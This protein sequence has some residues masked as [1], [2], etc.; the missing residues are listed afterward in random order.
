MEIFEMSKNSVKNTKSLKNKSTASIALFLM[1]T[2][3]VTLV[4]LPV[5]NAHTP[6]WTIVSYAYLQ[7]GPNPVGVGQTVLILMW[8]DG[9]MRNAALE[10]DIRRH[11]YTLTITAPDGTTE[12]RN[13]PIILDPTST[14]FIR[15]TPTQ[16]GTYTLDFNYPGQTYTW[17]ATSSERTWTNDT[18]TAASATFLLTV[19]DEPLPAPTVS[20]PLPTEYW[21]R[22]IEGQNTDWYKI[23]SN[24]LGEPFI[25]SGASVGGGTAGLYIARIQ[26]DGIAPNSAHI[27]WS[28]PIQD[29]GVVGGN[30]SKI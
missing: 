20:Y 9:P 22:P 13:W 12:V 11:D 10:N 7:A 14:Q 29:G 5:A 23:S 24:W 4:A 28:K 27:L 8:V 2:I 30:V 15:Y 6:P 25:T 3:A 19:Q 17:N 18:F 16:V 26:P 21:T 1:L